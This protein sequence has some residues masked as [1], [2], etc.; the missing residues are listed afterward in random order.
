MKKKRNIW[1]ITKLFLFVVLLWTIFI[2]VPIFADRFIFK[3]L[4][5][6]TRAIIWILIFWAI[7]IAFFWFIIYPVIQRTGKKIRKELK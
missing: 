2:E 1:K 4:N 3:V 7:W 5:G 6:G